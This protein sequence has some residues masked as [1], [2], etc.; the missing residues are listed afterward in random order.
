MGPHPAITPRLVIFR[1]PASAGASVPPAPPAP[2]PQPHPSPVT[3]PDGFLLGVLAAE[4]HSGWDASLRRRADPSA[5]TPAEIFL[6]TPPIVVVEGSETD[7]VV[8][9]VADRQASTATP[10]ATPAATARRPASAP[11]PPGPASPSAPP[12][13]GSGGAPAPASAGAGGSAPSASPG[14]GRS[15]STPP[16]TYRHTSRRGVLQYNTIKRGHWAFRSSTT[17]PKSPSY[18]NKPP[19]DKKTPPRLSHSHILA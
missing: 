19:C 15:T 14:A 4:R 1:R 9:G 10:A 7:S 8:L 5:A 17:Q 13:T 16:A 3:L 12:T 18:K 2:P 11:G 6:Q